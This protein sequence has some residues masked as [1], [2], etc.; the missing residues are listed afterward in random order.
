[1]LHN[2]EEMS[3]LGKKL[4]A[5]QGQFDGVADVAQFTGFAELDAGRDL[6]VVDVQA[7]YDTFCDHG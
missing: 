6:A 3:R 7:R 5:A 1:M 4:V 2:H